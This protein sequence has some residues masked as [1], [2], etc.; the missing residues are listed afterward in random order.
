MG[1]RYVVMAVPQH[2]SCCLAP[3]RAVAV[4]GDSISSLLACNQCEPC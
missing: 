2:M 3:A 4:G 1:T